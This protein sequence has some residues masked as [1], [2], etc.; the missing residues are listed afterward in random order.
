MVFS[1]LQLRYF[2]T[3]IYV[4]LAEGYIGTF[5]RDG[6]CAPLSG[7]DGVE[8]P[9]VE[10]LSYPTWCSDGSTG[11]QPF[12]IRFTE[13]Y[14]TLQV[15]SSDYFYGSENPVL[16]A[17]YRIHSSDISLYDEDSGFKIFPELWRQF[18]VSLS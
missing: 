18:Q 11:M 2:V 5:T 7:V 9:T 3:N 6:T 14:M 12:E 4:V 10:T 8:P 13:S 16:P 17:T 1:A 15:F